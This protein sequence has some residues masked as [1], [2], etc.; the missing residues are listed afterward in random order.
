M[1][2]N[3][4]EL[5]ETILSYDASARLDKALVEIDRKLKEKKKSNLK[6]RVLKKSR[7]LLKE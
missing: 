4:K 6:Y 5:G 2:I 7:K 1:K 3:Y